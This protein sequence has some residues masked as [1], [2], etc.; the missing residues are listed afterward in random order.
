MDNRLFIGFFAESSDSAL[1]GLHCSER[2]TEG[3]GQISS[4]LNVI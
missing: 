2:R 4:K 1:T 3:K